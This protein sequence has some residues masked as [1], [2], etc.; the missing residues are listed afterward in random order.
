M[1]PSHRARKGSPGVRASYSVLRAVVRTVSL[2]AFGLSILDE[3]RKVFGLPLLN[4]PFQRQAFTALGAAGTRDDPLGWKYLRTKRLFRDSWIG[5]G[6][7]LIV[8]RL[9]SEE[10]STLLEKDA[11]FDR[12]CSLRRDAHGRGREKGD[13]SLM[14]PAWR[15]MEWQTLQPEPLTPKRGV[16]FSYSRDRGQPDRALWNLAFVAVGR[17]CL[18]L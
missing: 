12:A 15:S 16:R 11:F 2:S 13:P 4:L 8:S 6:Y 1:L 9:L 5:L 10:W 18:C 14:K 7:S 3:S 17:T